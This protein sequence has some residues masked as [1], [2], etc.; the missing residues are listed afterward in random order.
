MHKIFTAKNGAETIG[1]F[2]QWLIEINEELYKAT[3]NLFLAKYYSDWM[4]VSYRK[5]P[6]M[7]ELAKRTGSYMG[8]LLA[9]NVKSAQL[10]LMMYEVWHK[11]FVAFLKP[12]RSI[13]LMVD[14]ST[15]QNTNYAPRGL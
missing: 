9:N 2:Q 15:L 4:G 8:H 6:F 5:S 3:D 13:G 7:I 1:Q 10:T 14:E 12:L 11:Q